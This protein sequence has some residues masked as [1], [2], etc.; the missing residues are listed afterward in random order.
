M[1]RAKFRIGITAWVEARGHFRDWLVTVRFR[2]SAPFVPLLLVVAPS[3]DRSVWARSQLPVARSRPHLGRCNDTT[4][5]SPGGEDR[6]VNAVRELAGWTQAQ[7][8]FEELL[9]SAELAD[10]LSGVPLGKVDIDERSLSRLAERILAGRF[11]SG[12]ERLAEAVHGDEA[13]R[14]L[15]ERMEPKLTELVPL[16]DHPLVVPVREEIGAER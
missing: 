5:T 1:A 4:V 3:T 8:A 11:Q 12:D 2:E 15:L 16:V 7:L 14:H 9:A 6:L 13:L 10:G